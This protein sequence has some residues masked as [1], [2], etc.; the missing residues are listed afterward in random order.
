MSFAGG[1]I[2][3]QLLVGSMT[4]IFSVFC[5]VFFLFFF[6]LRLVSC[7]PN[8]TSFSGLSILHCPLLFS[9]TFIYHIKV[10][11][12]HL[13]SSWILTHW[14]MTISTDCTGNYNDGHQYKASIH[15][16]FHNTCF[17]GIQCRWWSLL[18]NHNLQQFIICL[19]KSKI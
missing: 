11:R 15:N 2:H 13:A 14:L 10:H 18:L 6:C 19:Y 7:V 3:H 5:V 17:Y 16:V 12:I 4:L 9:L 8:V 1:W